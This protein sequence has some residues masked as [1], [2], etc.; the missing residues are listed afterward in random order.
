M[1]NLDYVKGTFE[2]LEIPLN[3]RY[4]FSVTGNTLFFASTGISSYL[5]SSENNN[6]YSNPWGPRLICQTIPNPKTGNYL[7]SAA[8][9]S[10][11]VETGLSNSLSLLIAP[12][13]KMPVRNIG[14]GQVQMNTVG[15]NFALKF[16]PVISRR[17]H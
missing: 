11:G 8:T 14:F 16:A 9:L 7:F 5:L 12:Y 6:Y 17:R 13:V 4:D 10:V 2:M 15:I 1:R 3:L